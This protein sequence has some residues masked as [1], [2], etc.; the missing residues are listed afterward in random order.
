MYRKSNTTPIQACLQDL[1]F[2]GSAVK[3]LMSEWQQQ[4]TYP[5]HVRTGEKTIHCCWRNRELHPQDSPH[6]H[7]SISRGH[8]F[9]ELVKLQVFCPHLPSPIPDPKLQKWELLVK[10]FGVRNRLTSQKGLFVPPLTIT[11]PSLKSKKHLQ[12]ICSV[13]QSVFKIC[14][15]NY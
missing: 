13:G 8:F 7:P 1:S 4:G 5:A 2:E 6:P 15:H 9:R 14:D 10:N 3:V 11:A 12:R